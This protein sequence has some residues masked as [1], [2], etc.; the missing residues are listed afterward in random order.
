MSTREPERQLR[1][2]GGAHGRLVMPLEVLDRTLLA[3]VGGKAAQLGELI[4]AGFAVPDGFCIT[5]AA[6]AR[7]SNSA[8][9][10]ALLTELSMV[11]PA[12]TARQAALAASVRA[13]ILQA[14]VPGEIASAII[15]AYQALGQD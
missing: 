2:Q 6:Y 1:D 13:A 4:R 8:E 15:E 5:T 11:P 10:D 9:L 14:P 7:I 12:D 3:L